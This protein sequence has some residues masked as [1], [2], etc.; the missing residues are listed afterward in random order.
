M[1]IPSTTGRSVERTRP[2]RQRN[3]GRKHSLNNVPSS[4]V[5]YSAVQPTAMLAYPQTT[6]CASVAVTLI[7]ITLSVVAV[8]TLIRGRYQMGV[9]VV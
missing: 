2:S 6:I 1:T 9:G 4:C 5:A 3:A 7:R 8:V